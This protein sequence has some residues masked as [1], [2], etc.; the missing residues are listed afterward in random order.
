MKDLSVE[1]REDR[2]DFAGFIDRR[3]S[4]YG[5]NDYYFLGWHGGVVAAM[6]SWIYTPTAARPFRGRRT[7]VTWRE[8]ALGVTTHEYV[9][10]GLFRPQPR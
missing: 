2:N 10:M 3:G 5:G 6:Y 1:F 9:V 4:S 7:E 8:A